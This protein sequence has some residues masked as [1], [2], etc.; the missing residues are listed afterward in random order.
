MSA[1]GAAG[2]SASQTGSTEVFLRSNDLRVGGA[3][4][5]PCPRQRSLR[6]RPPVQVHTNSHERRL[7]M[8][9]TRPTLVEAVVK[10]IVT[11]TVTY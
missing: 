5:G 7:A 10:T 11:H 8:S 3:A 2:F 1:G 4:T 6:V 9:Q